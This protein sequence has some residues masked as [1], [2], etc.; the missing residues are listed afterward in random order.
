V[1]PDNKKRSHFCP[2]CR[3]RMKYYFTA[4]VLYKYNVLYHQCIQCGLIQTETP[5]WLDEAYDTAI[6]DLDVGLVQRNI[7]LSALVAMVLDRYFEPTAK[8]LDFAGGYGLFVRMMRDKGF[9]FYRHD[10]FC[11]N[12]FAKYFDIPTLS[13]NNLSFELVT[14]FEV[15]EHFFD[16]LDKLEKIF[17]I[18][19]SV[20]LTT[21]ILPKNI[22]NIG[23][24]L[25]FAPETGQHI[26]FYTDDSIHWIAEKLNVSCYT[27]A[28]FCSGASSC[29][30]LTR[31]TL[32]DFYFLFN[33]EAIG[34]MRKIRQ[35]L[36]RVSSLQSKRRNKNI[37]THKDFEYIKSLIANN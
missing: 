23:D 19:D 22:S 25:Y 21:E 37:S 16:P 15:L 9:D 14:A 17:K 30:L 12:I 4:Q 28:K 7:Q 36:F 18:T 20:L 24:W 10:T 13:G 8:Y 33:P 2:V 27:D 6:A 11:E 29:F 31:K 26:T 3:G 1:D 35:T 32:D 5:Y 34:L